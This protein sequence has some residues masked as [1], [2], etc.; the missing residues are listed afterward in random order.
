MIG[1]RTMAAMACLVPGAPAVA[2]DAGI[3]ATDSA[4]F[5]GA[6]LELTL[7]PGKLRLTPTGSEFFI[8]GARKRVIV[9]KTCPLDARQASALFGVFNRATPVTQRVT[10]IG[11]IWSVRFQ[12]PRQADVVAIVSRG[13]LTGR[14]AAA[15]TI[16][17]DGHPA[18][19]GAEQQALVADLFGKA[20]CGADTLGQ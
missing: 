17:L 7:L 20:G 10:A 12:R 4:G 18:L 14:D 16:L 6:E 9:T 15:W 8:R 19:L 2:Q 11:G 3:L 5:T 1:W 13:S